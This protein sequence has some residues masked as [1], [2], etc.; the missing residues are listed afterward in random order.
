[1][2]GGSTWKIGRKQSTKEK[3]KRCTER[4][5][6]YWQDWEEI[7]QK[8]QLHVPDWTDKDNKEMYKDNISK[9]C[10]WALQKLL[11][12]TRGGMG[13]TGK[14]E[15]AR[16]KHQND[17]NIKRYWNILNNYTVQNIKSTLFSCLNNCAGKK[18][19][20]V[21]RRED[22][23]KQR[24]C[25]VGSWCCGPG[26]SQSSGSAQTST[27]H[28]PT[29]PT[30]L[31]HPTRNQTWLHCTLHQVKL[32]LCVSPSV[33]NVFSSTTRI[34]FSFW[35]WNVSALQIIPMA[36]RQDAIYITATCTTQ[37]VLVEYREDMEIKTYIKHELLHS[38]SQMGK[39]NGCFAKQQWRARLPLTLGII[40]METTRKVAQNTSRY[41][42]GSWK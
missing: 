17:N 7:I 20:P 35:G 38:E 30:L 22:V 3:K 4:V 26:A 36:N 27:W 11:W 15:W 2:K 24:L 16:E 23:A 9:D 8:A 25:P 6:R 33:D 14:G 13:K 5:R 32:I 29:V 41:E 1:M 31:F 18:W 39:S 21:P 42:K 10:C 34:C 12:V 37:V 19:H 28:K 40:V